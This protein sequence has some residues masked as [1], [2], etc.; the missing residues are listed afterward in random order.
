MPIARG[1]RD[2]AKAPPLG[3]AHAP[4]GWMLEYAMFCLGLGLAV[5][6]GLELQWRL[7]QAKREFDELAKKRGRS[8]VSG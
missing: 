6:G 1:T 8:I 7:G 3:P 5:A 4:R 2:W